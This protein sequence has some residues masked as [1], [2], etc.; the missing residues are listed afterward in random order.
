MR[1]LIDLVKEDALMPEQQSKKF[2][3]QIKFLSA[4]WK[5]WVRDFDAEDVMV[6]NLVDQPELYVVIFWSEGYKNQGQHFATYNSKTQILST[7]QPDLF[8]E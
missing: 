3:H 7:N 8:E 4:Q 6:I 1:D 5:E 2:S